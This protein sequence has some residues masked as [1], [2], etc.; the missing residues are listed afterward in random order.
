MPESIDDI[1]QFWGFNDCDQADE[2]IRRVDLNVLLLVNLILKEK[3]TTLVQVGRKAAHLIRDYKNQIEDAKFLSCLYIIRPLNELSE[4]K[5]E[6]PT[7]KPV[8]LFEDTIHE[9]KQLAEVLAEFR[10]GKIKVHKVFCYLQNESGVKRLVELGLIKEKQVSSLFISHNEKEYQERCKQLHAY[11]RSRLEPTDSDTCYNLYNTNIQ[12]TPKRLIELVEPIFK[13][14]FGADTIEESLERG[15]ATNIKE[16]TYRVID[17]SLL[18]KYAD[19]IFT[20]KTNYKTHGLNIRFKINRKRI[21]SD[22]SVIPKVEA[23]FLINHKANN[24]C[25]TKSN[26]CMLDNCTYNSKAINKLKTKDAERIKKAVCPSCLDMLISDYLLKKLNR[27]MCY[28]FK[29]E[30]FELTLKQK[31]RPM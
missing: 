23:D 1:W 17:N 16:L 28:A 27:S 25:L 21:D 30:G 10:A 9:G 5:P 31:Y 7:D 15:L 14:T 19:L 11:F 20:K 12:L 26:K 22:F 2:V 3:P 18:Q 6:I 4:T 8:V 24:H 13:R 29:K